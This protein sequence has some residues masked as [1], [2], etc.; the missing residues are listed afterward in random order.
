MQKPPGYSHSHNQ[1]TNDSTKVV[2]RT[3]TLSNETTYIPN[4]HALPSRFSGPFLGFSRHLFAPD[5]PLLPLPLAF[6]LDQ[7]PI[8]LPDTPGR[9]LGYLWFAVTPTL[10]ITVDCRPPCRQGSRARPVRSGRRWPGSSPEP[11][12]SLSRRQLSLDFV[13]QILEHPVSHFIDPL[14][15]TTL[16]RGGLLALPRSHAAAR[17][18]G[19]AFHP[20]RHHG[21][22]R[23]A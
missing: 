4:A 18:A 2:R 10:N 14:R 20:G 21:G 23:L 7:L 16:T 22:S 1:S 11:R 17:S 9:R 15:S 13:F 5:V 3:E 19:F 12:I 8:L 6:C